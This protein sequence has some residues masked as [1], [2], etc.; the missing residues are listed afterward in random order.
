MAGYTKL[1]SS[2]LGSTV[3]RESYPT[4]ITWITMLALADRDGIVEASLPGLA[5]LAGVT[6]EEAEKAVK[7][8]LSEDIYSR[9][10]EY[11][12]RRI[13]P[14]DG[15][16]RLLNH[17]KYRERMSPEDIRER[18]RIRKQR[19]REKQ[20]ACP[21]S[22][23]TKRDNAEMS[24][25]SNIQIQ[26]QKHNHNQEAVKSKPIAHSS[27]EHDRVCKARRTVLASS[28]YAL[29]PRKIGKAA[30]LKA[31]EKAIVAV[32]ASKATEKHEDFAGDEGK[33][34]AWLQR[35]VKEFALSEHGSNWDRNFV[36]YPATWFNA[37][38]YD[39]DELEWSRKL[40]WDE[41]YKRRAALQDA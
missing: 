8:F 21:T 24:A 33:A 9:S 41:M 14:T 19:Q 11:G 36:P 5:H 30:A 34:T 20:K 29:Y 28:I 40:P 3:W 32:A 38:R 12:G 39:D 4:R 26:I 7:T 18:D 22:D 16:W 17:A 2:I 13:E 23:G 10:P 35:R 37:S 25:N 27:N 1:F 6:L 31:I 15:G